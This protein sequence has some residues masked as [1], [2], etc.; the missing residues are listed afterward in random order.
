MCGGL[1]IRS[2]LV[3]LRRNL[4]VQRGI[5]AVLLLLMVA[6]ELTAQQENQT[7][8]RRITVTGQGSQQVMPNRMEIRC[9]LLGTGGTPSDAYD[10]YLAQKAVFSEKLSGM[11]FPDVE[12][13]FEGVQ[14]NQS[15]SE[16]WADVLVV[17][18][19]V[20]EEA[21]T[22]PFQASEIATITIASL[23]NQD[24]AVLQQLT[25]ELLSQ[26]SEIGVGFGSAE[27]SYEAMIYGSYSG[28]ASL[29]NY[30]VD[31]VEEAKQKAY[32]A[33]FENARQQATFLAGLAG[34]KPGRVMSLA[35]SQA[36]SDSAWE[37]ALM[38]SMVTNKAGTVMTKSFKPSTLQV[39]IHVVF[40]LVGE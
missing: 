3:S 5:A 37:V 2:T 20:M 23:E 13:K 8:M 14:M 24:P 17:G 29:V 39:E 27:Q 28:A 11:R 38:S 18:G 7:P 31:G 6:A 9:S 30:Y 10:E 21:P 12:L 26:V 15:P 4:L 25:L 40:E 34:A 19:D 1:P 35:V 33:A 22:I 36:D 16:P 32:K